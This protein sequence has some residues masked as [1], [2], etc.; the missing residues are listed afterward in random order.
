MPIIANPAQDH[1]TVQPS[2]GRF[3]IMR[4]FGI[5]LEMVAPSGQSPLQHA[6]AVV[7]AAGIEMQTN[8]HFGTAYSLWQAKPDGS[9]QPY[10]RGVEVVSRILPGAESS[11]DEIRR[12]VGALETAGFGVNRSCGFHVHLNVADLPMHVRQ[13]I[14][15]RYAELQ[16]NINGMLPPS[17]RGNNY[18][19]PLGAS[20]F[21]AIAR[22]IESGQS[23]TSPALDVG[24]RYSVTNTAWLNQRDASRIEF[25]QAAATCNAA[26]VIGWVRFLQEMVDEV[27]RRA[28]GVS[29]A[30][31]APVAPPRPVLTPQL[32]GGRV[33]NMRTGSDADR[34]LTQLCTTG[35]VTATWARANGIEDNI[36]RRIVTGWRRH[37]APIITNR[38]ANGPSY[39]LAGSH[40]L[41]VA[42]D[43]VFIGAVVQSVIEAPTPIPAPQPERP[44]A[45]AFV[46]YPF[47][48]GLSP[49]TIAWC[50]DR[51]DTFQSSDE[52]NV[53][54]A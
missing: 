48:S 5:E 36:L 24:G 9:I 8:S 1:A 32:V 23:A 18:C 25:R 6:N 16:T 49:A 45:R 30:A 43:R 35:V 13:L 26:K 34:A 19:P 46:A 54:A 51:R 3:V 47:E 42:R 4:K 14:V 40:A 17:R 41:P 50:A 22:N 12:A 29:F 53:R 21:N 7:R 11:Y 15:L 31:T 2:P 38:G 52:P 10:D 37:G 33:P 20:R 44:S 39:V 27:A 28:A